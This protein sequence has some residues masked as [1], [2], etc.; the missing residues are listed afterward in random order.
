MGDHVLDFFH[1]S[2]DLQH[3]V[4]P[5]PKCPKTFEEKKLPMELGGSL[6]KEDYW[7]NF[8]EPHRNQQPVTIPNAIAQKSWSEV[9]VMKNFAPWKRK[10]WH[11]MNRWD[12]FKWKVVSSNHQFLGCSVWKFEDL[13]RFDEMCYRD[14]EF[15]CCLVESCNQSKISKSNIFSLGICQNHCWS[16]ILASF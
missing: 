9:F 5:P 8:L 7:N 11:E 15:S 3:L 16:S 6:R 14:K 10:S 2:I 4:T 1:I 12:H 13:M